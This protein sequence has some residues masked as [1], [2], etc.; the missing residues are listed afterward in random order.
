M[1]IHARWLFGLAALFNFSVAFGLLLLDTWL[2]PLLQLNEATGSNLALRDLGLMLIASF[3]FA[4]LCTAYSPGRF[5]PYVGLGAGA[6]ILVVV[7]I[8]G[9]WLAGNIGWQLPAL[10]LG[11]VLFAWLFLS[12][13]RQYPA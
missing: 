13:L 7:A 1:L 9:H 4:Y 2:G 5:R 6:K 3:G 10:A 11:D 12:F 8:F